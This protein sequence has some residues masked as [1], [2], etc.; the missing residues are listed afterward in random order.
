MKFIVVTGGVISGIGKG[1]TSSSIGLI[2]K[3]YGYAVTAIKI[4]P[5]LNIDSGT[6]SPSEHGECYVLA[7]G[8]ECDLDLGNY[9]RFLD[10]DLTSEHNITTG[11]IY[12]R[13]I[14]KE[15]RGAFLGKT[16]Q[17]V[18][19]V[20]NEIQDWIKW[21]ACRTELNEQ[22]P[23]YDF[24]IV[25]VGGTI[26]D[27]EN[28][29]FIEAIRQMSLNPDHRF[30]FVHVAMIIDNHDELKTKPCQ[31]SVATLRSLGIVPNFLVL[32][33]PSQLGE[34]LLAKLSIQCHIPQAN[35]ISN[36][37]VENIYY[38][39]QTFI[40]QSFIE[41]IFGHFHIKPSRAPDFNSYNTILEHFKRE[42]PTMNIVIAGKYTTACDTYLSLIRALDHASFVEGVGIKIHWLNTDTEEPIAIPPDTHAVII[43]GG[44]GS[45]GIKG[46]I[47]VARLCRTKDIPCLGICLG[48]QVM[49]CEA[50]QAAGVAAESTEWNPQ[51]EH[52]VIQLL[53]NQVADALGGTM[54]L[55]EY[56]THIKPGT[57]T[58]GLYKDRPVAVERHRHRYE[59]NGAYEEQLEDLGVTVSGINKEHGL[60]EMVEISTHPFY[61][62]CQFHPEYSSKN[63]KP[64]PLFLG[65][66]AVAWAPFSRRDEM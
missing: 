33:T 13:V 24:C 20:T 29:P 15:R 58:A 43:P 50:F 1:I 6:M 57:V 26:G 34:E 17:I 66:L 49:I 3:A 2:L 46:K 19:H 44:F 55:G 12:D 63:G 38:V 48:M 9:E 16:V 45:R 60:V 14:K 28:T 36:T 40:N 59:F 61:V 64:H 8:G 11:K 52:P 35:I 18:P 27:M 47:E 42:K 25:E 23:E 51:T 30:C 54:R 56:A 7:D 53:P 5:Y 32:R 10:I 39:P 65:L 62:G 37:D 4:D 41:K 21:A 22:G 31:H